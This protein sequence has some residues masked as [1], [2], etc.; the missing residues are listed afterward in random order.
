MPDAT[1]GAALAREGVA[2]HEIATIAAAL[3]LPPMDKLIGTLS[4]GER[5]RVAL[6]RALLGN[7]DVLALDEPTNHLDAH[8]RRVARGPARRVAGRADRRHPRSLLPRPRR[9][10]DPRGR[11][12]Q[13]LRVRGRLRRVPAEAGRAALDARP[14]PSTSACRS[15]A[16]RSSGSGAAHR[17][18]RRRPRRGSIG[19]TPRSARAPDR[20]RPAAGR[21]SG[22]GCPPGPRL[23]STIVEL[24]QGRQVA[25][26]Q[27][28]V[29]GPRRC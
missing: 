7:A 9:D 4:I 25:R 22:C 29:R 14:R 1:V 26:R 15:S 24:A 11:S 18:A 28:A 2:D 20:G 8:H 12:R 13:G 10:P 19:S 3:Q 23:G 6:A 21:S 27:A 5:R 16:A 17:R